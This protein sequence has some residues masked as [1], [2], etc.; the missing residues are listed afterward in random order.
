MGMTDKQK[1]KMFLIENIWILVTAFIY[2]AL[3]TLMFAICLYK[4]ILYRM[5]LLVRITFPVWVVI[6]SHLV[7]IIGL[8]LLT[9]ICYRHDRRKQIIEEIRMESI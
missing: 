9:K 8:M 4:W 7:S 5:I 1:N 2:S 3:I 6:M